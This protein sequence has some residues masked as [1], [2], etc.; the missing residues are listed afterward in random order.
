LGSEKSTQ[1]AKEAKTTFSIVI[2]ISCVENNTQ[3][4]LLPE[5]RSFES[6]NSW[7]VG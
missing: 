2:S 7:C 6:C 1:N 3:S 5:V 4:V